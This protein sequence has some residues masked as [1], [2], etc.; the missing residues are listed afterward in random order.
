MIRSSDGDR[1]GRVP[2]GVGSFAE[3][4]RCTVEMANR[5]GGLLAGE[6]GDG[7]AEP[8]QADELVDAM[9]TVLRDVVTTSS[10]QHGVGTQRIHRLHRRVTGQYAVAGAR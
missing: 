7:A 8:D 9:H 1:E 5:L 10:W 2:L 6:P 4:G 3:L